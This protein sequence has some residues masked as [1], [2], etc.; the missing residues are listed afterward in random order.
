[1]QCQDKFFPLKVVKSFLYNTVFV[2]FML[3]HERDKNN[4]VTQSWKHRIV[5]SITVG[6][7]S[8]ISLNLN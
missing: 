1:M 2:H 6:W 5:W 7:S 4:L 8:Q 3:E